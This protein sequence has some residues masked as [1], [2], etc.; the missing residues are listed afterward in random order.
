[1]TSFVSSK[2]EPSGPPQQQQQQQQESMS[3]TKS[4]ISLKDRFFRYFQHEITGT[5]FYDIC[6]FLLLSP[7]IDF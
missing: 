6:S 2:L 4:E 1:M 5:L 7:M 3:S